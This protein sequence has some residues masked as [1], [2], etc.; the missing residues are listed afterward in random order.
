VALRFDD[1]FRNV[2]QIVRDNPADVLKDTG[3]AVVVRDLRGRLRLALER[4]P[5]Q[6]D[7]L[8]DLMLRAAGP[9]FAGGLLVASE[10]LRA[11]SVFE[12][13]DA[14][15]VDGVTVLERVATGAEWTRPPLPNR[16]PSPP[17][18]TLYGIKGGVGR[19]TVLCA[20]AQHL[21]QRG[22]RVLVID[23]DLE[24]PGVSSTLMPGGSQPELGVVDWLVEDAVGNAD[25]ELL[26]LMVGRSPLST[27][28]GEVLVVPCGGGDDE[29]YLPKLARAY[30][31]VALEDGTVR[32]FGERLAGMIDALEAAHHPTVVLI[33]SRAGIHDL[34]GI[35]TTRLG[36]MSFLFAVASRQTWSGYRTL[37]RGW[38]RQPVIARE[39]R[40][41]VRIVAAQV[42][43]TGREAYLN[44]LRTDSYD[45][46]SDTLYEEAGPKNP[47]AFNFDVNA[48]DAPHF[49]LPVYWSR[50]F[51]EW[52]PLTSVVTGDQI[53]AAFG[54]FL[55]AATDLLIDPELADGKA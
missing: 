50:P 21:A 5:T 30:L 3:K 15:L 12:S 7:A 10:M 6:R 40:E 35:A 46:F 31:D 52:D 17:R 38:K 29:E 28:T 39:V 13:T 37:L 19:S 36:A 51:Q 2:L 16:E 32:T 23:L 27:G 48:T 53:R 9:F 54:E 8:E 24:S 14:H 20:W 26:R 43:E 25:D 55:D 33:D 45:L 4:P 44:Q 18:A 11:S 34:A 49:A 22:E 42:P 47:A 41:R 1:A